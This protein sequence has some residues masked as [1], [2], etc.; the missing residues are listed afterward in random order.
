MKIIKCNNPE[1]GKEY[2]A[3]L[4]RCPFC[5]TK[6]E[7]VTYEDFNGLLVAIVWLSI[8][9]GPLRVLSFSLTAEGFNVGLFVINL[10]LTLIFTVSLF[11]ILKAKKWAFF[12]WAGFLLATAVLNDFMQYGFFNAFTVVAIF[13]ILIMILML[14]TKK[15]G[16]SAWSIMF[17]KTRESNLRF[18]CK[19]KCGPCLRWDEKE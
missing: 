19:C 8:V 4:D 5:Q 12:T 11:F 18:C 6:Q 17:N 15:N 3:N 9:L 1:C 2:D 10:I 16:R 14:H 13:W 7:K